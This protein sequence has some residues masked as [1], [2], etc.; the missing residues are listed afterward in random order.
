MNRN[1][2]SLG[3]GMLAYN[4]VVLICS[5]EGWNYLSVSITM[6]LSLSH[7]LLLMTSEYVDLMCGGKQ[8]NVKG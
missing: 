6:M 2:I 7:L 8:G 1:I 4:S 3:A 5:G